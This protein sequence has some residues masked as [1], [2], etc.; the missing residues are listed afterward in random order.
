MIFFLSA[1]DLT[2]MPFSLHLLSVSTPKGRIFASAFQISP[3]KKQSKGPVLGL[4]SS[5]SVDSGHRILT[6]P[7]T[8]LIIKPLIPS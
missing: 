1:M 8:L 7:F 5:F 3:K 2:P 4:S 6:G